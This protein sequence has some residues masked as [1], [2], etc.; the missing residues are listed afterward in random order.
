MQKEIHFIGGN[1]INI[2]IIYHGQ[3]TTHGDSNIY[4]M[5]QPFSI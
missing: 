1:T 3:I 5:Q 4:A 2:I